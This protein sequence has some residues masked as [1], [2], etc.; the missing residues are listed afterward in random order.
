VGPGCFINPAD[1]EYLDRVWRGEDHGPAAG[2][3]RNDLEDPDEHLKSVAM[4]AL[5]SNG[6]VFGHVDDAGDLTITDEDG[7]RIDEDGKRI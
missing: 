3:D 5:N 1:W 4:A 6:I 2:L 7:N